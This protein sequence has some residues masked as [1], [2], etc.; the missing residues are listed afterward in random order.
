MTT[1][2]ITNPS[3]I[4][5]QALYAALSAVVASVDG[6]P[7]VHW[8]QAPQ[9]TADALLRGDLP[10]VLIM[11]SQSPLTTDDYLGAAGIRAT[12]VIRALAR[13][14]DAAQALLADAVAALA[15]GI[16]APTGLAIQ[17]DWQAEIV[18]PPR[19]GVATAAAQY[20]ATLRRV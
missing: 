3:Y 4:L 5:A 7:A 20:R 16:A 13:D 10:G 14:D 6:L 8:L 19:D 17:L 15:A 11:Q 1:A 2:P 9:G 12:I 18:I